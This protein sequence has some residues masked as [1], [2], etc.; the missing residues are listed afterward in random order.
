MSYGINCWFLEYVYPDIAKGSELPE[1]IG[2]NCPLKA[3]SAFNNLSKNLIKNIFRG[4]TRS[5]MP[6]LR[7][8]KFQNPSCHQATMWVINLIKELGINYFAI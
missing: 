2:N 8:R 4:P 6:H 7:L 5:T 3:V 1:D